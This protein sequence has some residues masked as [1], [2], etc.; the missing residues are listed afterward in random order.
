MANNIALYVNI[1]IENPS[2]FSNILLFFKFVTIIVGQL[3][4]FHV[5]YLY[6]FSLIG[7]IVLLDFD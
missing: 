7:K 4:V 2:P 5:V 6:Y 1:G 3:F